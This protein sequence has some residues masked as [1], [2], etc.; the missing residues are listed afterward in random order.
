MHENW[1]LWEVKRIVK[2]MGGTSVSRAEGACLRKDDLG[3]RVPQSWDS[4][5]LGERE[6]GA[7][8]M[9]EKSQ[10]T[11]KTLWGVMPLSLSHT[12]GQ[13]VACCAIEARTK[14]LEPGRETLPPAVSFQHPLLTRP[15]VV[16]AGRREM[17]RAAQSHGNI[18]QVTYVV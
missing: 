8:W 5:L 10:G 7:H 4:D 16:P 13:E 18:M 6:S 14:A 17:F 15:N 12:I 1:L 11:S 9:V 3:K 2:N